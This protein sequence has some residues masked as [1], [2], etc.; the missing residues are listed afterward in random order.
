[1]QPEP[2]PPDCRRPAPPGARP[3]PGGAKRPPPPPPPPWGPPRCRSPTPPPGPDRPRPAAA[4]PCSTALPPRPARYLSHGPRCRPGRGAALMV[5]AGGGGAGRPGSGAEHASP[6]LR[7]ERPQVPAAPLRRRQPPPA[8]PRSRRRPPG[9]GCGAPRPPLPRRYLGCGAAGPRPSPRPAGMRRRRAPPLRLARPMG[10]RAPPHAPP[11]ARA[12]A[13]ANPRRRGAAVSTNR[14]PRGPPARAFLQGRAPAVAQR[15]RPAPRAP[16]PGAASPGCGT[17]W[18][19]PPPPAA[20]AC[21]SHEAPP[22]ADLLSDRP[23]GRG[24]GGSGLRAGTAAVTLG[25][26]ASARLRADNGRTAPG[27][28]RAPPALG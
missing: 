4:R 21:R 8:P 14:R 13:A 11:L 16:V 5:P 9:P 15:R 2:P 1:M 27:P 6:L 19:R 28:T 10:G 20:R 26:S 23:G 3:R 12:E 18:G 25:H 22:P 24:G 7:P 17:A